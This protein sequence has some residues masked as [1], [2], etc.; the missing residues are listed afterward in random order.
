MESLRAWREKLRTPV[1]RNAVYL[2]ASEA[3]GAGLGL[4]FWAVAARLF[5]NDADLGVGAILITGATLLATLSTLGFNFSLIRFLPEGR[6]PVARLINS[7]V[8]IGAVVAVVLAIAFGLGTGTWVPA[9]AFLAG[10]PALLV[11]FALFTAVWTVS[12]LFDAAFIGLGQAR[13]VL[14]RAAVYNV[15]K[16]PLP[17][18]LVLAVAAPFAMFSAWGIGLLVSN[19]I[20]AVFLIARVVPAYRLRPDLDTAAVGSMVRYS[21]ASH[22]TNVL[23][24]IPGL[25]FPLIVA[26]ALGPQDA[27]YFY[28]AWVLANFLFINPASIF[29]SVFAEGSRW[30]PGLRGNAADGLFLSLAV[31]LP[32]VIAVVVAGPWALAALKPSFVLAAPLLR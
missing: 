13:Y 4:A 25:V 28:I 21:F 30:R 19:A 32:A 26:R 5:P 2:I 14:L 18:V 6:M 8:T 16:V 29:T 23:G 31:L 17:A 3:V 1:V 9:L 15:L 24:S 22:A 11:L 20:A 7:S 10:S 12:L 27:A